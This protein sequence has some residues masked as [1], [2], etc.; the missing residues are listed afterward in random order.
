MVEG[1]REPTELAIEARR[2]R[3]EA[4]DTVRGALLKLALLAVVVGVALSTVFGL[5]RVEGTGMRPVA[6]D[7]DLALLFRLAEPVVGDVVAYRAADKVRVGRV[8]A[9]A[10]DV[11]DVT[12]DGQL[13]VNGYT[14]DPL[15]GQRTLPAEDGAVY[16][17]TVGHG[18]VF[19]LGDGRETA[20]DSR[21]FGP[22][23]ADDIEGTVVGLFR[24]RDL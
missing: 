7:G 17:V 9:A 4:H 19:L 5:A 23:S 3:A 24:R 12:D 18:E 22:V 16:P 21:E 1:R 8:V 20:R 2:L 13:R 10:G 15:Y 6:G 14:Q 11:V